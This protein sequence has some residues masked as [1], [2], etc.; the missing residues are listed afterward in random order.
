[1]TEVLVGIDGSEVSASAFARG[2]AEAERRGVPVTALHVWET[3]LWVGGV[4]GLSYDLTPSREESESW[5]ATLLDDVVDKVLADRPVLPGVPVRREVRHGAPHRELLAASRDCDLVVLGGRGHGHLASALLG[6]VTN[7]VLH[8]AQCPVMLVPDAAAAAQPWQRVVVG[9]DG[10]RNSH[11]ALTWAAGVA[12]RDHLPLVV[13]H[14]W[15]LTTLPSRPPLPYVPPLWEY[16]AEADTWLRHEIERHLPDQEGLEVR[17][18]A[19]HASASAALL[20]LTTSDD[21]LVLGARGRGGFSGL[22]LG[23]VAQQC[24]RHANGTLVVVRERA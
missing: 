4:P 8:S 15:L 22:L 21:L 2:L 19:V 18:E 17:H 16:G 12:R 9:I 6:S 5:A 13:V 20:D 10:S 24:A 1:M 14:A 11:Q 3:P 7:E 23:S